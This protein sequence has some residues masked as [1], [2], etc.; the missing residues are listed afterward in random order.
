MGEFLV[1][2]FKVIGC[3]LAC[4]ILASCGGGG[5][6]SS[7]YSDNSGGND[8]TVRVSV[9]PA[10]LILPSV[11]S[12]ATLNAVVANSSSGVS[13]S[14]S[15]SGIV[16]LSS[17]HSTQI[18]AT[19]VANGIAY[20]TAVLDD[21]PTKLAKIPVYI[22]ASEGVNYV[23]IYNSAAF[24]SSYSS[25]AESAGTIPAALSSL[26]SIMGSVG[27]INSMPPHTQKVVIRGGQTYYQ[28]DPH[29]QLPKETV[30]VRDLALSPLAGSGSRAVDETKS[31]RIYNYNTSS[32]AYINAKH[33][34]YGVYCD[35][36]VE[37][38][39]S[40][41]L[42][43]QLQAEDVG[44]KFDNDIR[45]KINA[46][47][48]ENDGADPNKKIA[49]LLED[50]RDA[51]YYDRN[52]KRYTA[53]YFIASDASTS[54]NGAVMI[55]ID[56]HPLMGTEAGSYDVTESYSTIAH[57]FQHIINNTDS[58]SNDIWWNE[59]F[60]IAAEYLVCND[61]YR[62]GN[63]ND[64][65]GNILTN[66]AVLTY[67]SYGDNESSI[68][69]NYGLPFFFGI[70]LYTQGGNKVFKSILSS[71][72]TDYNA[73]M[74]GLNNV[75]YQKA[76]N[77]SELNRN[78]RVAMIK[79]EPSGVFGFNGDTVVNG[80]FPLLNT[81]STVSLYPTASVVRKVGSVF[82]RPSNAGENIEFFFF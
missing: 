6:K 4:F 74:A 45:P 51:N 13:W 36:Y 60:S 31:F 8:G 28:M 14:T 37:E 12:S 10:A 77:F 33:H 44:K 30:S 49:I 70:Y 52:N 41:T 76:E 35:V 56:I 57:E 40:G 26:N 5:V 62:V 64:D 3:L 43:T 61:T 68:S 63:Y 34:Y 15:D 81:E 65:I 80:V 32:Y 69:A 47:F 39:A 42:L 20:I 66:G 21:S 7:S 2:I 38:T 73:I 17:S 46:L 78:F 19:A 9:S 29:Y 82:D 27:A 18:T 59:A 54:V 50:I 53:G 71:S 11:G 58:A 55:H 25:V 48:G 24:N 72:Y 16:T 75:G 1:N 23:L 79:K 67:K 22:G